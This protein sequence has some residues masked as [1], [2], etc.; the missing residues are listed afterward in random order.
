[1]LQP[2]ASLFFTGQLDPTRE[3][4]FDF[5]EVL[6]RYPNLSRF[7]LDPG[8]RE[9]PQGPFVCEDDLCCEYLPCELP[10]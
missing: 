5:E 2:A 9:N 7:Y 8:R 1:M 10:R 3:A 6:L 4:G